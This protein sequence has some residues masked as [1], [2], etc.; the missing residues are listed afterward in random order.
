MCNIKRLLSLAVVLTLLLTGCEFGAGTGV[1]TP[2]PGPVHTQEP[3]NT[4]ET[5]PTPEPTPTPTPTPSEEPTPEP[6]PEPTSEPYD[7][8]QPTPEPYDYTQPVPE[9][10]AV[11]DEWFHDAV[12]IGDS[13]M[14]GMKL[15]GG[16]KHVTYLAYRGL[17]IFEVAENKPVI[18]VG[19][20]MVG[21]LQALGQERYEKVYISLGVNELGYNHNSQFMDTYKGVIDQIRTLQ[22]DADVYIQSLVPVNPE[23]CKE[24][25]QPEYVTNEKIAAYNEILMQVAAEQ[26]VYFV[27]V[28]EI[29]VN[30]E[31]VLPYE[32]TN[33][34]VHLKKEGYVT[35][36][37]YLKTHTVE[38]T[39]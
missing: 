32:A 37:E 38:E 20:E 4:P 22:P 31:G 9:R 13:R 33:D 18:K 35:W 23:R 24:R 15:Y 11:P 25:K 10:E 3:E 6:T 19:E 16:V 29:L 39:A 1:A 2:A 36:Y 28:K 26:E 34:G 27:N 7:Y 21:V 17:S 5:T 8:T 14:E 30:E 12:F